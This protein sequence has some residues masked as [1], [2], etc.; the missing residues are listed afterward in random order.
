MSTWV[1]D[2]DHEVYRAGFGP[3]GII[4][5]E[6]RDHT[7]GAE[8]VGHYDEWEDTIGYATTFEEAQRLA[9]AWVR[10]RLAEATEQLVAAEEELSRGG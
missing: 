7:W 8:W 5:R 4:I 9:L 3:Y 1:L 2:V 6:Y 10:E